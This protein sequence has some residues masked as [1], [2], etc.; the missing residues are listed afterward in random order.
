MRGYSYK[1]IPISWRNRTVGESALKLKEQGSRYLY[2]LLTVWFEW[3]LV[4]R[5]T[6]RTDGGVFVP[7]EETRHHRTR[8]ASRMTAPRFW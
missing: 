7:W 6:H 5:D 8:R 4:K 1:V 2:T 3:L